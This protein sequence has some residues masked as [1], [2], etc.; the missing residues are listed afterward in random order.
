MIAR[1]RK[2]P[3]ALFGAGR[4][5][6]TT[7]MTERYGAD[8]TS[9]YLSPAPLFH[10]API[11]FCSAVHRIGAT[12]VVMERFDPMAALQAIEQHA[13]THAQF[14][15]THF[16][17]KA[18]SRSE[19][20]NDPAKTRQAQDPRGL[21]PYGDI[22]HVGEDGY[23]Y[24][25]DRSPNMIISGGVNIYP[26]EAEMVLSAHPDVHDVAVLGV[27][28]DEMGA[29]Q[30]V[31]ARCK[32]TSN[33]TTPVRPSAVPQTG[34]SCPETISWMPYTSSITS[35]GVADSLL[36]MCNTMVIPVAGK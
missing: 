16:W 32:A 14:V 33:P 36:F 2:L 18:T 6:I 19:Y 21:A 20:N 10:S 11:G 1:V 31:R 30:S 22:G 29:G 28:D 27:P 23:L 24:L 17:C 35:C 8:E 9:V 15:P 12:V 5:T 34:V 4:D 13:V 7:L 26:Q 3:T 25:T